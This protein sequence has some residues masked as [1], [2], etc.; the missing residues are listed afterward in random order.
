[1]AYKTVERINQLNA[2]MKIPATHF[3]A[4]I[5]ASLATKSITP[6]TSNKTAKI[7][8]ITCTVVPFKTIS[9]TPK[10]IATIEAI[11]FSVFFTLYLLCVIYFG[12][13]FFSPTVKAALSQPTLQSARP[14]FFRIRERLFR[15]FQAINAAFPPN[16][17]S[18]RY[19]IICKQQRKIDRKKPPDGGFL[20]T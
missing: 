18:P 17:L 12:N 11:N 14:I 9:K 10:A 16:G 15:R 8:V 20:F 3:N 7:D 19:C 2:S 1:M 5:C 6:N 13:D 4:P